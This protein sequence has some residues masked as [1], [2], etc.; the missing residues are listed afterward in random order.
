MEAG[1]MR[2]FHRWALTLSAIVAVAAAAPV[3]AANVAHTATPDTGGKSTDSKPA[4]CP[5]CHTANNQQA[6]YPQRAGGALMRGAMNTAFGWTELV[7]RPA[8]EVNTSGNL[9]AGIASGLGRAAKRTF[10]GVGEL[11]TFWVPKGQKGYLNLT[12]DCPICMGIRPKPTTADTPTQK[13]PNANNA[14]GG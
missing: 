2:G 12:T 5:I 14:S 1:L 6:V 3:R 13:T 4:V 8:E 9:V 7:T 10:L 11:F